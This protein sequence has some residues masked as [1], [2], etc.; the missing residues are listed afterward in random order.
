MATEGAEDAPP[1][2]WRRTLGCPQDVEPGDEDAY[3]EVLVPAAR[4]KLAQS[5]L[6][7]L[8]ML[9]LMGINRIIV[10]GGKIRA[11]MAFH[12]DTSDRAAQQHATDFDFRTRRLR[13]GRASGPGR[14]RRRCRWAT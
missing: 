10:T 1:P 4:R 8:S 14:R 9:V 11:T 5:R 12:V 7:T 13:L 6:Q 2:S 3:E